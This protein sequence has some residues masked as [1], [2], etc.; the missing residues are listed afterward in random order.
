MLATGTDP[1]MAY[2]HIDLWPSGVVVAVAATLIVA[3]R[4]LDRRAD[5]LA[6]ARTR[7]NLER[8]LAEPDDD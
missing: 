7:R 5:A 6:S 4:A 8:A 2:L 3:L 1:T